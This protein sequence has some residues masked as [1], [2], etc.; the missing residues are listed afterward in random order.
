MSNLPIPEEYT[1][2]LCE[3][4]TMENA[5]IATGRIKEISE[6]YIKIANKDRDMQIVD[7]GTLLKINVFNTK[8]GFRV[9]VGNVYTSSRFELSIVSIVSLVYCERRNFF[10]VDMSL[11]SKVVYTKNANSRTDGDIDIVIKD[12]SLSGLRFVSKYSFQVGMLVMVEAKLSRKKDTSILC[13]IVRII[14]EE[15]S[16]GYIN[17]GCEIIHGTGDNDD[18]DT[19][20]SFLFQKQREFLSGSNSK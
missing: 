6:K 10:R 13:K 5:L 11:D 18:T 7:F 17:Y 2:S 1:G 20:C 9:L 14:N 16:E 12:M 4:K 3:I 8:L 15:D 19:L